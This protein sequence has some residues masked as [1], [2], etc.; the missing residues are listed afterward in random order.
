ME[1]PTVKSIVAEDFRTAAIFEKYSIDFCCHGNVALEEACKERG[2]SI[3]QVRADLGAIANE[4]NGERDSFDVWELDRLVDYIVNTH[5]QYIKSV[6]P[7]LLAHTKKVAAVHGERH[8]ELL[9]MRDIFKNVA[10]EMTQHMMKEE[11]MLFP[12]IKSLVKSARD[13]QP[14]PRPPFQTIQN[15]IRMMEAE[16]VSAGNGTDTIRTLS[17]SYAIPADACTTFR[18]TYQELE[19]FELDLHKHVYLEN[20]ILFPKAIVLEHKFFSAVQQN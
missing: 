20:N 2:V 5:H 4:Q 14:V 17:L 18:V 7:N 1:Q 10:E 6:I 12:Y 15:P 13:S 3:D 16:H 9:T 8:G 19:A 11:L